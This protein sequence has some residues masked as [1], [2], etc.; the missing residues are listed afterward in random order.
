[1][2]HILF[3]LFAV[4]AASMLLLYSEI[5]QAGAGSSVPANRPVYKSAETQNNK[6]NAAK[7]SNISPYKTKNNGRTV[8]I[9]ILEIDRNDLRRGPCY[10]SDFPPV[11]KKCGS[12]RLHLA[13]DYNIWMERR[14]IG[15][16]CDDCNFHFLRALPGPYSNML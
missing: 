13:I 4:I 10:I 11:C 6:T 12:E 16:Y 14:I 2:K 8:C 7:S 1:M 3:C 9:G 5:S 15:W